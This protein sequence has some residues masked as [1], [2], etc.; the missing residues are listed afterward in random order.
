MDGWAHHLVIA[1]IVL[2]LVAGALLAIYDERRQFLKGVINLLSTLAALYISVAL[3][4]QADASA[5]TVYLLGNWPAP[6]GIVLVLD[7]L[8]AMMILLTAVLACA[9][10]V[11][12]L[13]RWHT[14]G[15][16]FIVFFSSC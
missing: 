1:P 16:H 5:P 11:F 7:R 3:L 10:L 8:S 14:A 13:A 6:F 9:A 12:A 2:P 4:R 15:A